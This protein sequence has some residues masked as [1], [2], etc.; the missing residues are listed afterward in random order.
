[1]IISL[2]MQKAMHKQTV[3]QHSVIKCLII[4]LSNHLIH[5]DDQFAQECFPIL[6]LTRGRE[7]FR[8]RKSQYISRFLFPAISEIQRSHFIVSKEYDTQPVI[9]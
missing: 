2:E 8:W 7:K 5:A 6:L 3:C 4:R 9:L 1:M